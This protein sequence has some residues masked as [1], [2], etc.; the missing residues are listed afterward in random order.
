MASSGR[1][2]Y[3]QSSGSSQASLRSPL[4]G[5]YFRGSRKGIILALN[6]TVIVIASVLAALLVI[7]ILVQYQGRLSSSAQQQI[8]SLSASAT[9]FVSEGTRKVVNLPLICSQIKQ[10]VVMTNNH[11]TNRNLMAGALNKAIGEC[12]K[13][14][15]EGKNTHLSSQLGDLIGKRIA[16]CL[17]CHEITMVPH[18]NDDGSLTLSRFTHHLANND[19][20][21]RPATNGR[22]PTSVYLSENN[23]FFMFA[24][25]G[26][27]RPSAQYVVTY[28]DTFGQEPRFTA[29]AITGAGAGAVAGVTAILL[30]TPV[31]WAALAAGTVAVVTTGALTASNYN[32]ATAEAGAQEQFNQQ[33]STFN[34][35]WKDTKGI[36]IMEKSLFNQVTD[37]SRHNDRLCK[38]LYGFDA[39]TDSGRVI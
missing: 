16:T 36:L 1:I 19:I 13:T 28:Y 15:G 4:S 17:P 29:I 31:G 3:K 12:W 30:F 7:V 20:N 25:D 33:A 37:P 10:E 21:N 2:S 11:D 9:S 18:S 26:D 14:Y 24:T 27:I 32:T 6:Q 23:G 5:A 8:C 39:G 35:N 38:A 34:Y 22:Q